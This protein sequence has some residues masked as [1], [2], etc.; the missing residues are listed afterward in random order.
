MKRLFQSALNLPLH[1]L[2]AD[3]GFLEIASQPAEEIP[4]WDLSDLYPNAGAGLSSDIEI[5]ARE[6]AQFHESYAGK[7]EGLARE[8]PSQLA[9]VLAAYE[10]LSDRMGRIGSFAYLNYTTDTADPSRA[11]LFGDAQ[12]KLTGISSQLLFFELELNRIDDAVMNAALENAALGHYRPWL[13]DLRKDRPYQLADEIEKLFHEKGMTGRASWSRL[14]NETLTSLRFDVDGEQMSLEPT[15]NLLS[16]P[17]TERRKSAAEALAKVFRENARVFTLV[18]NTLA[19]DKEI[20]DRWRRFPDVASS[21]HLANRVE[22]EVVDALV[23]AVRDSYPRLS[24][25]YYALKAKWLGVEQLNYWDRNA[26]ISRDPEPV[27]QWKDAHRTVIEAYHRFSPSMAQ[28]ADGF[29]S[30][31]WIDAPVRVGKSPGAFSHPTVPSAH[32][33]IMMNYMGKPRD[34]MTLAHELGHGVHQVLANAQGALMAYTPL[35]LAET[36]SVFGE[37]LTFKALLAQTQNPRE[38]KAL[39]AQK[40]EDKINT[41]VRQIAFYEFERKVH[42]ARREGELTAEQLGQFWLSVQNESLGPAIKLNDGYENYWT[43]VSHFIHSPFYVYAY[44]FGDCLVNSLY[45]AYE[46][47]PQGFEGRYLDMLR[48]GGTKHHK[49]LLAPFGLDASDPGFWSM[50]LKVIEDMITELE[51][52]DANA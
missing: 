48:A 13:T 52:F 32:P 17:N 50:G 27:I 43:Y 19:K 30:K 41:V 11:K 39:L 29:F 45:A 5:A 16:D 35:T 20:S 21:R 9:A 47:A 25:R 44:A 24:H 18:T 14:F 6:A 38:R 8:N 22:H 51:A 33:Y 28:I 12:D 2:E 7:L 4:A 31:R 37:M 49:E 26:P 10:A 42:E 15:L 3:R 34:V 36:A 23:V 1:A 40:V 46:R